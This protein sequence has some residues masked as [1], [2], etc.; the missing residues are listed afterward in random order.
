MFTQKALVKKKYQNFPLNNK[1]FTTA[2]DP[3][4]QKENKQAGCTCSPHGNLLLVLHQDELH[5]LSCLQ[6]HRQEKLISEEERSTEQ[7]GH[8]WILPFDQPAQA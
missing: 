8:A 5:H 3:A 4:N 6:D 2:T 7:R 1:V